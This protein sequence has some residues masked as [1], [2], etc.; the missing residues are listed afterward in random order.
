MFSF[1]THVRDQP[2]ILARHAAEWRA[3]TGTAEFVLVDDCSQ[4][5]VPLAALAAVS[6]RLV[7]SLSPG[8]WN[9]GVKNLGAAVARHDWLMFTNVDHVLSTQAIEAVAAIAAGARPDCYYRFPRRNPQAPAES[10]YNTQHHIGTLLLHRSA[11]DAIGGYDE[12]F[13]GAYGHDDTWMQ[14]CL[15]A[16]G[17]HEEFC[18]IVMDNYSGRLDLPDADFLLKPEWPRDLVR[19]TQ[20]LSRK[21][22]SGVFTA[23]QPTIRFPWR[24]VG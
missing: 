1:I 13:C 2:H 22:A 10:R 8:V 16:H 15:Q 23:S 5:P 20:I 21:R 24:L 6:G 19:N 17:Y 11:F 9:Y 3:A 14:S 18:E 12:D 4:S 7:R